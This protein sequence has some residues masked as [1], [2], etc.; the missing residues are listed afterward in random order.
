MAVN[1]VIIWIGASAGF[2]IILVTLIEIVTKGDLKG[3]LMLLVLGALLMVVPAYIHGILEGI[4]DTLGD[5][6]TFVSDL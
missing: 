2:I 6:L 5:V 1:S 3:N 4:V